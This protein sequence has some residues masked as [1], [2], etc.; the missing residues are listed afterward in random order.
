MLPSSG[1][2]FGSVFLLLAHR[3]EHHQADLLLQPGRE[4]LGAR[5]PE[6]PL[7]WYRW[8]RGVNYEGKTFI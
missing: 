4:G 6:M 3:P 7:L 1:L 5:L 8:V 2:G